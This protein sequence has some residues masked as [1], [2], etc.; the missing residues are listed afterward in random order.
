MLIKSNGSEE[1][2]RTFTLSSHKTL[3][4]SDLK[5][6]FVAQ[7]YTHSY[8]WEDS[9]SPGPLVKTGMKKGGGAQE[10]EKTTEEL[11]NGRSIDRSHRVSCRYRELSPSKQK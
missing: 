9:N 7:R 3:L 11:L 4:F 5:A 6:K 10:E 8:I 1:T 2:C